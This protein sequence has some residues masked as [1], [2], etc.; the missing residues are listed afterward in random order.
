MTN[1][2][3]ATKKNTV[4]SRRDDLHFSLRRTLE[5]DGWLFGSPANCLTSIF[6]NEGLPKYD[7]P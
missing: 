5:K 7:T 4:M 3:S 6:Q 1:R 2:I